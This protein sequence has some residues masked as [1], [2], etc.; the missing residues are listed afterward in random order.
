MYR[1][2]GVLSMTLTHFRNNEWADSATDKPEHNGLTDFGKEV[3]REI[4][5]RGMLVDVSHASDKTFYEAL[6]VSRAP[7]IASHSA[8]R[9]ISNNARNMSD[10]MIRALAA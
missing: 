9:A 10:D 8:V 5:R 2:M 4:N 7:V 6:E 3:I 1:R